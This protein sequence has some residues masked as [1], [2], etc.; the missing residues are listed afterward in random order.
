MTKK[1]G[2]LLGLVI[3]LPLAWWTLDV[4]CDRKGASF[5]PTLDF[6]PYEVSENARNV[7]DGLLV[8]DLHADS[9]LWNRNLKKRGT[10]GHV[11]LPRLREGGVALQV[12]G[13][14]T[15]T[16]KGQNF[17]RNSD[18]TDRI[19]L[20]TLAERWPPWT[21]TSLYQRARYQAGRLARLSSAD[22]VTFVRTRGDLDGVVDRREAGEPTLGVLLGLEGAHALEGR[23]ENLAGLHEAGLRMLGLAHFFDNEL[24]GSAHGTE[25]GGLT[26]LGRR[27][28]TEAERLGIAIDLAHASPRAFDEAVRLA[29][30]PVVVSH[31]GVRGTCGGPRNL[32]DAQLKAVAATGG[33]VGIGLFKGAVCGEDVAATLDAIAYAVRVVGVDHVALGSDFDGAV[34]APIHVGGLPLL[35]EGLLERGFSPQDVAKIMGGN[36]VRVLRETL[37]ES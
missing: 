20:L 25:K 34:T 33:V 28:V 36:V 14:V 35:T 8:A 1:R 19:T 26:E 4:I 32:T 7:H 13:L 5:N 22:G 23:F 12:F 24:A 17:E 2:V 11:D 27:V 31:S 16:P 10:Y 3:I 6:G 18:E 9:L 30:K 37:P 15:K 29:A 21:W